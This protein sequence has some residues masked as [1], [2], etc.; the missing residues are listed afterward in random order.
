MDSARSSVRLSRATL[1]IDHAPPQHRI[2]QTGD[3][4][5]EDGG[6]GRRPIKL[7]QFPSGCGDGNL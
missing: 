7:A 4:R 1:Q 6:R 2:D 3:R 5:E